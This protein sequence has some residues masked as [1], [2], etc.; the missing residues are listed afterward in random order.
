MIA[1][2]LCRLGLHRW[3]RFDRSR[4]GGKP[5]RACTRCGRNQVLRW[6]SNRTHEW[7]DA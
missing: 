4:W 7:V 6:Y 1:L 5:Y 2:L 3:H